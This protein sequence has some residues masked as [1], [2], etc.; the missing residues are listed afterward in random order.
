MSKKILM[1]IVLTSV[2]Y[3]CSSNKENEENEKEVITEIPQDKP[4]EVKAKLLEYRDFNYELISNGTIAALHKADLRFQSQEHI[5]KIYVKN[6]ERV[7]KGQKL[8]ELDK[9]KLQNSMEQAEESFERAK[10]DLQDVLIGQG[11]S[12][13]DSTQIPPEIMKIAKIR[14]NHEQSR[15][16]YIMAK[17]N[18][19]MTT[20]YAPFNGVIANLTVKEYNQPGGDPFCTIVDNQNPEVVFHILENELALINLNDKVIVSPFSQNTYSVEGRVSEMNPIIDKNGMVRVKAVVS[21]RDNK[22]YEGMNVKVR[23]QR[24]LDK[25]LVIPKSAVVLRTNKKVVFTLKGSKAMWN[26][27]ETA[28]ENSDSYVLVPDK[29]NA[30]DS[31]IYDGNMNLMDQVQV[32]VKR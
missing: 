5:V 8:A 27:V 14:S 25:Q 6:G 20:L 15:N 26:Y 9:F 21:N 31:V 29:I 4:V 22:F 2:L 28:Q 11:Y 19:D 13:V 1:G 24:L 3:S 30:G 10:L 32:I 18:L 17:Y 23:V 16:N 12:L 7:A